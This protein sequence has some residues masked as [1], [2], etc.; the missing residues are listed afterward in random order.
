MKNDTERIDA[1]EQELARLRAILMPLQP[2]DT[3]TLPRKIVEEALRSTDNAWVKHAFRE[4][5]TKIA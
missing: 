3:V 1:L 2:L 5:L 4:A